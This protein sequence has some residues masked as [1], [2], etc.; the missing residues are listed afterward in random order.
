[1]LPDKK[2]YEDTALALYHSIAQLRS[3]IN[4]FGEVLTVEMKKFKEQFLSNEENE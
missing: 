3:N 4:E 1:M 2:R